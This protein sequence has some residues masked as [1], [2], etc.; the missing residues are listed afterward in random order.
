MGLRAKC[1]AGG[2]A[3]GDVIILQGG[4]Y[5]LGKAFELEYDRKG[6]F[7]FRPKPKFGTQ[8]MPN[9]QLKPKLS[10]FGR[11]PKKLAEAEYSVFDLNSQFR[12]KTEYSASAKLLPNFRP[13]KPRTEFSVVL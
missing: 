11:I 8:K 2:D 13:K 1:G 3:E 7:L 6:F 10:I 12:P 5:G 4:P 9:I